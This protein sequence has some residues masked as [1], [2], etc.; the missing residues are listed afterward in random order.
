MRI[1]LKDYQWLA[2]RVELLR[3][4]RRHHVP[5]DEHLWD[6]WLAE[7]EDD[8]TVFLFREKWNFDIKC[9]LYDARDSERPIPIRVLSARTVVSMLVARDRTAG[10]IGSSGIELR[11]LSRLTTD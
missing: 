2:Q 6:A 10:S 1:V 4:F 7:A 5:F 8:L 3:A 11:E 9:Y